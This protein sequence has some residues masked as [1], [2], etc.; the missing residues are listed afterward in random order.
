MNPP[1]GQRSLP[2]MVPPG[3]KPLPAPRTQGSLPPMIPPRARG[4][5]N[6]AGNSYQHF[7]QNVVAHD[8]AHVKAQRAALAKSSGVQPDIRETYRP[9]ALVDGQRVDTPSGGNSPQKVI[10][11]L[12]TDHAELPADNHVPDLITNEG[13]G[14]ADD[15]WESF[16]GG[17]EAVT[18]PGYT[19]DILAPRVAS[20]NG[21]RGMHEGPPGSSKTGSIPV[22]VEPSNAGFV[23]TVTGPD[24][25]SSPGY[26]DLMDAAM[27][28]L[29][30]GQMQPLTS[31]PS[32][33]Y[34]DLNSW[35]EEL[36][37]GPP[38]ES[39]ATR[40]SSAD[41][42]EFRRRVQESDVQNSLID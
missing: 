35:M 18:E 27:E 38:P 19:P 34:G 22:K 37:V 26:V 3:Q 42:S 16:S 40:P 8:R 6:G 4:A 13:M 25:R 7:A 28:D 39:V 14:M 2:P 10:K 30:G 15:Q 11:A 33:S 29:G 24:H 21:S 20:T 41:D 23:A 1:P 5:T 31:A 12:T 9:V 17:T 32:Q 36:T